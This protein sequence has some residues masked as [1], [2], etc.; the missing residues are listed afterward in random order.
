MEQIAWVDEVQCLHW[1]MC[2]PYEIE[3][4]EWPDVYANPD[5][6][7]LMLKEYECQK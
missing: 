4:N 7:K 3:E 5:Q 1:G 6:Y 2:L